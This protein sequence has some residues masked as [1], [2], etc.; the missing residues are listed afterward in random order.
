MK[1]VTVPKKPS[2]TRTIHDI[3]SEHFDR[4]ICFRKGTKYAVIDAAY[5]GG[6]GYK[7]F[8]SNFA[9]AR[10][11]CNHNLSHTIIDDEGNI[12]HS[13][14]NWGDYELLFTG[15]SI[16]NDREIEPLLYN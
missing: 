2:G 1:T 7:T 11:S 3:A 4:D 5:Y 12:Y 6:K 15:D 8:K 10:F 14:N 16:Q 13:I 9:A